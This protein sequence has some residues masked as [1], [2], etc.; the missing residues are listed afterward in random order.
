MV[1]V[2]GLGRNDRWTP[3]DKLSCHFLTSLMGVTS[4]ARNRPG[5]SGRDSMAH[6]EGVSSILRDPEVE[7]GQYSVGPC[8]YWHVPTSPVHS[9]S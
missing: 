7:D 8:A 5:E 3:E 4:P 6:S 2:A 9:A 1:G